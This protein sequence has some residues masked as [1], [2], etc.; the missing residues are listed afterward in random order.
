MGERIERADI[1]CNQYQ[2]LDE[3]LPVHRQ[4]NAERIANE[5]FR[6]SLL[7]EFVAEAAL[8]IDLSTTLR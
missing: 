7:R 3:F 8:L 1:A 2:G 6:R 4:K 5:T